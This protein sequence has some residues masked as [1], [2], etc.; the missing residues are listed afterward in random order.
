MKKLMI[1]SAAGLIALSACN[2]NDKENT[3]DV[4]VMEEMNAKYQ[5]ANDFKDSLLLLMNDIYVGLDS[6]NA[7][8]GI[9]INPGVGDNYDRRAEVQEN[10]TVIRQRLEANKKLL[11]EMEKKANA[12]NANS[13]VLSAQ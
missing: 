10:L 3:V 11:A 7:Q 4:S 6:I 8:E 12:A 9:L 2:G 5:E 13:V 1:L